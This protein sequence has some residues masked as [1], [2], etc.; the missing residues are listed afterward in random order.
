MKNINDA[1]EALRLIAATPLSGESIEDRALRADY[2]E[3]YQYDAAEDSFE[4][5]CDTEST[6]LREAVEIARNV[7]EL[8]KS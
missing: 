6:Q 1:V 8:L 7:L 4:P 3:S 2:V 5:S